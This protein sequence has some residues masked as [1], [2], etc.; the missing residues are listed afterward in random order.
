MDPTQSRLGPAAEK[1]SSIKY[2]PIGLSPRLVRDEEASNRK[3]SSTKSLEPGFCPGSKCV[4]RECAEA[5]C[6]AILLT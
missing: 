4:L 5:D 3:N 2:S 1:P 6:S